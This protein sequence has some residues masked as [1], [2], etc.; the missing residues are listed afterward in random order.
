MV[1]KLALRIDRAFS[2]PVS[3][4]LMY[5]VICEKV[6]TDCFQVSIC[7]TFTFF[8]QQKLLFL[9]IRFVTDEAGGKSGETSF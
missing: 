5:G 8:L 2:W 3:T 7:Q 6:G 4:A 1:S 9:V